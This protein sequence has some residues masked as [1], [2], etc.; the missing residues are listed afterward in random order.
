MHAAVGCA[1]NAS[2]PQRDCCTGHPFRALPAAAQVPPSLS[3]QCAIKAAQR[4]A[5]QRITTL[6]FLGLPSS[7]RADDVGVL[8][9]NCRGGF[10][11][12]GGWQ[13]APGRDGQSVAKNP[14]QKEPRSRFRSQQG[15]GGW[16]A[17]PSWRD[18]PARARI[19][20][21]R[22]CAHARSA[23]PLLSRYALSRSRLCVNVVCDCHG[24]ILAVLPRGR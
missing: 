1:G 22:L 20:S 11:G 18:K 7:C 5:L 13:D 24:V 23:C 9:E 17:G 19:S 16:G 14:A 8:A 6:I 15:R 10:G 4:V 21:V 2:C 12:R 3:S